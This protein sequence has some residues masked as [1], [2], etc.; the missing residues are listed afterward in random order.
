MPFARAVAATVVACAVA[1]AGDGPA[2]SGDATVHA[3]EIAASRFQFQPEVLD[4]PQGELVRL[5][6]RSTDTTH[7]IAIP[8]FGVKAV[9]PKGGEPVTVEFVADR[10]GN[11]PLQCSEYCG[12]GH[13]RMKGRLVVHG[14]T[15][16]KSPASGHT[17]D[18]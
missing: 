9:I 16:A 18:R 3:F 15:E 4:V 17:E 11:F 8:A 1:F 5:T 12:F 2:R 13:R 10:A 6:L 14:T 7:G